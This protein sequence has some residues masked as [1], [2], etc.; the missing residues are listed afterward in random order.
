MNLIGN[1][2]LVYHFSIKQKSG[3]TPTDFEY[4]LEVTS[5]RQDERSVQDFDRTKPADIFLDF[6]SW[7]GHYD[8]QRIASQVSRKHFRQLTLLDAVEAQTIVDEVRKALAVEICLEQFDEVSGRRLD[9][10][11]ELEKRQLL[12]FPVP[13]LIE[14][15]CCKFVKGSEAPVQVILYSRAGDLEVDLKSTRHSHGKQAD[16]APYLPRV[17]DLSSPRR[18]TQG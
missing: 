9:D 8:Q 18:K 1:F 3:Q 7:S 10:L 15:T 17:L 12:R 13:F 5:I 11:F 6:S 14:L 16:R 2:A 4:Q